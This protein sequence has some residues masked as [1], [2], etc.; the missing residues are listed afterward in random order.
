MFIHVLRKEI[1]PSDWTR[2]EMQFGNLHIKDG[3]LTMCTVFVLSFLIA[4][5]LVDGIEYDTLNQ[6]N[7]NDIRISDNHEIFEVSVQ[8]ENLKREK[9]HTALKSLCKNG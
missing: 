9:P 5:L 3:D 1:H 6:A 2:N 7:L 4:C 8:N